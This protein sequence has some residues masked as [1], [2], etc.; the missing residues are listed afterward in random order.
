MQKRLW[1][2]KTPPS[3]SPLINSVV[4]PLQIPPD[5]GLTPFIKDHELEDGQNFDGHP[6]SGISDKNHEGRHVED[7]SFQGFRDCN[8][9]QRR[10]PPT[11]HRSL[12]RT[13][14]GSQNLDSESVNLSEASVVRPLGGE[15][16]ATNGRNDGSCGESQPQ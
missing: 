4:A 14:R 15:S 3:S 13:S 5:P 6:T 10:S 7:I 1:S 2:L 8:R 9:N 11:S 12:N 16:S